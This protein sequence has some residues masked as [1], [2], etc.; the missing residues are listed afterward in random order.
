MVGHPWGKALGRAQGWEEAAGSQEVAQAQQ[1]QSIF[2]M[3]K[4]K[5][6]LFRGCVLLR[7]LNL[8]VKLW[9]W[10]FLSWWV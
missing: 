3:R 8:T 7:D 2:V 6:L 9:A 10:M 1:P 5:V 4:G